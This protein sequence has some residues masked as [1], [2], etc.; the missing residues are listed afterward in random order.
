MS[1]ILVRRN[2]STNLTITEP[3]EIL[4]AF[5]INKWGLGTSSGIIWRSHSLEPN[6]FYKSNGVPPADF[7]ILGEYYFDLGSNV[8]YQKN[9]SGW[10]EASFPISKGEIDAGFLRKNLVDHSD[11]SEIIRD[12]GSVTARIDYEPHDGLDALTVA[13]ADNHMQIL[14]TDGSTPMADT[15]IQNGNGVAVLGGKLYTPPITNPNVEGAIWNDN[16]VLKISIHECQYLK[17]Y[18]GTV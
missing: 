3:G 15:Y 9:S 6:F 10:E 8:I 1:G 4:Y 2:N 16:G 18:G 17:L 5:D 11:L 7:G 13:Q 12:A 14:R